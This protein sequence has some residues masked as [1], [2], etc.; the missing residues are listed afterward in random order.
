MRPQSGEAVFG[1]RPEE[2]MKQVSARRVL[3]LL[4]PEQ[5]GSGVPG[6]TWTPAVDISE[7][8]DAY[9]VAVELPGVKLDDLEIAY[10]DGL[11]GAGSGL[12]FAFTDLGA[13]VTTSHASTARRRRPPIGRRRR[14]RPGVAWGGWTRSGSLLA[15][16]RCPG[17]RRPSGRHGR[18]SRP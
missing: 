6:T 11:R 14:R 16:R 12:C 8:K 1:Q 4:G 9:V 7:R 15:G 10:Q 5:P 13:T 17:V 2:L 3:N 18:R